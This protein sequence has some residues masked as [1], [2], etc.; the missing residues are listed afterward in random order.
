[1][2]RTKAYTVTEIVKAN[3][4]KKKRARVSVQLAVSQRVKDEKRWRCELQAL[5]PRLVERRVYG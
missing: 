1:M 5:H 2:P 4:K 3:A